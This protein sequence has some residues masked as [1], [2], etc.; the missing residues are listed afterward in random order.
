[1]AHR[2][3]AGGGQGKSAIS[4][5]RCTI[6]ERGGEKLAENLPSA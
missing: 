4:R 2:I 3:S 6:F 1:M 5:V